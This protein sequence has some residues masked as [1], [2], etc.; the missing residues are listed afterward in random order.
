MTARIVIGVDVDEPPLAGERVGGLA[1]GDEAVALQHHGGA[2]RLGA[3]DLDE[4]CSLG[5]HD[6]RRD[7]EPAG[8]VGDTLGMVA[9][10]HRDDPGAP[11]GGVKGQ[12]FGERAAFLERAGAVLCLELQVD[13]GA[14]D[15]G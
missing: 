9:G 10:G 15:L 4:G 8:V 13:L 5:H 14:G 7:P 2:K 11:L 12:Q 1:G 6:C 3:V